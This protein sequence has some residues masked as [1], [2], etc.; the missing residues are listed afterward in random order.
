MVQIIEDYWTEDYS[1]DK[2]LGVCVRYFHEDKLNTRLLEIKEIDQSNALATKSDTDS[3]LEDFK[4]ID[5]LLFKTN[6]R[7]IS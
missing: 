3:I 5:I 6:C 1:K 2:F 4:I 7:S